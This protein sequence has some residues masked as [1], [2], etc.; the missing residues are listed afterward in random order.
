M[1][2]TGLPSCGSPCLPGLGPLGPSSASAGLQLA[3][4]PP[5]RIRRPHHPEGAE[6]SRSGPSGRF[7]HL[8][9]G[10]SIISRPV[11]RVQS[12]RHPN[13]VTLATRESVRNS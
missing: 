6:P 13:Q 11:A 3:L 1:S 9:P 12:Q 4:G 8:A 10:D 7:A 2:W 5:S